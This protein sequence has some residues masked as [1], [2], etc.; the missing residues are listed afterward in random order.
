MS[1]DIFSSG[2]IN[3]AIQLLSLLEKTHGYTFD[4]RILPFLRKILANRAKTR[5][6]PNAD[7]KAGTCQ[8]CGRELMRLRCGA[9]ICPVC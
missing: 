1:I 9:I 7:A 8:K 5:Q 3:N 6:K 2:D 4:P